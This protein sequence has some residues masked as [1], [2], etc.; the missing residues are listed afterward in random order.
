MSN[1]VNIL[2]NA[3]ANTAQVRAKVAFQSA[4]IGGIAG[5]LLLVGGVFLIIAL[6]IL[7]SQYVGPAASA[8]ILGGVFTLAGIGALIYRRRKSEPT[9]L[10]AANTAQANAAVGEFSE[11][12]HLVAQAVRE[13]KNPNVGIPVAGLALGYLLASRF[14]KDD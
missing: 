5:I 12:A 14:R 8:A 4:V 11:V 13:V 10:S 3:F 7:G 2:F 6:Y 1:I 9:T